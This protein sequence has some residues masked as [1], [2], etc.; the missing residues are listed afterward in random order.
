V[1]LPE[2]QAAG[3][4]LADSG[5][6]TGA[7]GNLSIRVK[8]HLII[9]RHGSILSALI[10][11]GLVQT[12]IYADDSA[13]SLASCEL[14]VHRAIYIGTSALA[15]V[16]AHPPCA[17]TLSVRKTNSELPGGVVVVG[18]STGIVAGVLADEIACEL[19]KYPMVM[20]KRHGSFAIGKTLKEACELTVKLETECIELCRKRSISILKAS[21]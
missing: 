14:P 18:T 10:S 4:T 5:L 20:V 2:F 16:H 6:I 13:T 19:K 21:E 9:T 7:S 15:I 8:D 3:R 11:S 1:Y 12:G 17:V